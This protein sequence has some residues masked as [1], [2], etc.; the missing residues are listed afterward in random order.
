MSSSIQEPVVASEAAEERNPPPAEERAPSGA[1]LEDSIEKDE[2][3]EFPA[4]F[5][6]TQFDEPKPI[7]QG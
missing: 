3:P 6:F 1:K 5:P 2:K 7:W 4:S